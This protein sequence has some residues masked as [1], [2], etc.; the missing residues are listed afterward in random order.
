[1]LAAQP[2]IRVGGT[3]HD[4]LGRAGVALARRQE[5][6]GP[7]REPHPVEIRVI[8]DRQSAKILATETYD[9]VG[10]KVDA[11]PSATTLLTA[12]GWTDGLGVPARG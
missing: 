1:M 11:E 10:G 4:R 8:I 7:D 2:G 5:N 3:V 9:I 12:S 6:R